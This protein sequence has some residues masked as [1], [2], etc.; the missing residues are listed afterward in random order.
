[1]NH[2]LALAPC[3]GAALP[4]LPQIPLT[5]SSLQPPTRLNCAQLLVRHNAEPS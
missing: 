4:L 2:A 1:L 5:P 3:R